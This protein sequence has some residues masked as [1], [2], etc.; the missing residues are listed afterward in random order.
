M[1]FCFIKFTFFEQLDKQKK[2]IL[3]G[4]RMIENQTKSGNNLCIRFIEM[5]NASQQANY[6][7]IVNEHNGCWS[8]V[9][10]YGDSKQ[11]LGIDDYCVTT[12]TV[13]HELIHALGKYNSYYFKQVILIKQSKDLSKRVKK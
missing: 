9:G 8:Y 13:A 6:I 7:H 1:Y 2:I 10:R 12:H 5:Q 3:S 4:M 11:G